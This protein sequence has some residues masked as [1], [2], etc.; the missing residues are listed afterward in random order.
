MKKRKPKGRLGMNPIMVRT[1]PIYSA[2]H[3]GQ[4]AGRM[5]IDRLSCKILRNQVEGPRYCSLI[6]MH[7]EMH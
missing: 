1:R 6:V 5:R 2:S 4:S 7:Y 3:R